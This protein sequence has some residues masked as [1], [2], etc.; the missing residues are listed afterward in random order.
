MAFQVLLMT[1]YS[2]GVCVHVS[3]FFSFIQTRR[4]EDTCIDRRVVLLTVYA[5]YSAFCSV[6]WILPLDLP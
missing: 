2:N 5:L 6:K 4:E 1:Y 3:P